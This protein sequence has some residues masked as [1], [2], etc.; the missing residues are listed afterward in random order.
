MQVLA[1]KTDGGPDRHCS[2]ASVQLAYLCLAVHLDLDML[3]LLRTA[4]GQSY[5]NPVERVMSLLNLG[6]QGL[7]LAR[8]LCSPETEAVLK[9]AGGLKAIREA[10]T[11]ADGDSAGPPNSLTHAYAKSMHVPIGQLAS[12]FQVGVRTCHKYSWMQAVVAIAASN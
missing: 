11:K 7:A 1:I 4:P 5:V 12:A 3:I 8:V 10:L 9:G 6:M 2:H